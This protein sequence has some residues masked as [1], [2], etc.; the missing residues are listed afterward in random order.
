MFMCSGPAGS[1]GYCGGE[2]CPS[3]TAVC[4]TQ[5]PYGG[6]S[7]CAHFFPV[8]RTHT[9]LLTS[10]LTPTDVLYTSMMPVAVFPLQP[11][12]V[13]P[14]SLGCRQLHVMQQNV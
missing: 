6:Q 7:C 3:S 9:L 14:C 4:V 13:S 12:R 2:C 10:A 11:L 1:A 5:E 8:C